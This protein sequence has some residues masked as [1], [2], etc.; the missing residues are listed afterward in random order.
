MKSISHLPANEQEHFFKCD[1]CGQYVDMRN[2][3]EVF[4][5][6]HKNLPRPDFSS[7]RRLGDA[8]EFINP[9]KGGGKIDL[10]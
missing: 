7:S 10:N 9:A 8:E 4:E 6:E 5:H 2:L 1:L 3:A